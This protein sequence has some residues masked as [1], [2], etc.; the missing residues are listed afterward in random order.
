MHT[1]LYIVLVKSVR[2]VGQ[3]I[4]KRATFGLNEDSLGND[5]SVMIVA[6]MLAML[7]TLKNLCSLV[8]S[9]QYIQLIISFFNW[10][11]E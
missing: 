6:T 2:N 1:R 5:F 4:L 7:S 8:E 3:M 10:K 9:T 11:S